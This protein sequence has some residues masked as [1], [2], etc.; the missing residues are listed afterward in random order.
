MD[1]GQ[2]DSIQAAVDFTIEQY[3]TVT[4]LVNNVSL[5]NLHSDLDVVNLDLEEWDR[6]MDVN[7]KSVLLGSR[8]AIP[9]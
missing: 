8:F 4:V 7:L 9:P 6:L 5:T 3:G 1:A 2:A